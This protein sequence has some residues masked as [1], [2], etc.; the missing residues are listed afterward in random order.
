MNNIFAVDELTELSVSRLVSVGLDKEQAQDVAQVLVY[1]DARGINSHGVIR[2][3]HYVKRIKSGG[4]NLDSDFPVC[5]ISESAFL[6]DAKGGMGHV[7]LKRFSSYLADKAKEKGFVLGGIKNSSHAGAIGY[8]ASLLADKGLISLIFANTDP[9]V[10]PYG[11]KRPFLGTNPVTFCFPG[12]KER[13]LLDMATSETSLGTILFARER[14]ERIPHG[15]AVDESGKSVD[16]PER[17]KYLLPFGGYKGYGIMLM[18]EFLTGVLIGGSY[19]PNLVKMYGD[20]DKLRDLSVW[21]LVM[22]PGIFRSKEAVMAMADE[23]IATLR[24]EPP[25]E[26]TEKILIAGDLAE[27]N[28]KESLKSGIKLPE[29]LA[30]Y[31][32]GLIDE[33]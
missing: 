16:D 17:A 33:V 12:K 19:G 14:G 1:A 4:I 15:W 6:M 11:G 23:L 20:M 8:Y 29:K 26:G 32:R 13:F 28:Y 24:S 21:L 27:K 18:V 30:K 22:D 3:P 10:V 9:A 2:V 31:M 25:A 7:A 5:S